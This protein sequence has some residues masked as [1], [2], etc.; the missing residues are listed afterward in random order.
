MTNVQLAYKMKAMPLFEDDFLLACPPDHPLASRSPLRSAD[1][2][3]ESLLLLE[4]GHC[5]RDHALSACK[6]ASQDTIAADQVAYDEDALVLAVQSFKGGAS[7]VRP[8]PSSPTRDTTRWR[9]RTTSS[10]I[11]SRASRIP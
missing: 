11:P 5:L 1:L 10:S 2:K 9:A 6:I 4:E 3:G 8:S 7:R